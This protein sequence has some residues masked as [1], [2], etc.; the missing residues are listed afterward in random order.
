MRASE[1]RRVRS[2]KPPNLMRQRLSN[3]NQARTDALE[4]SHPAIPLISLN[5]S[6]R[7]ALEMPRAHRLGAF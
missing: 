1:R 5:A 7:D 3:F 2:R 4:F 6:G